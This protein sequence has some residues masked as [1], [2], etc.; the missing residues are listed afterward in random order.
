MCVRAGRAGWCAGGEVVAVMEEAAGGAG[1]AGG[2]GPAFEPR[3]R[4]A[5]LAPVGH[6]ATLDCRVLRLHDKSV[7][8]ILYSYKDTHPRTSQ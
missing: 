3:Q 1:G 2:A 6:A 5:V 4:T 7:S 8:T